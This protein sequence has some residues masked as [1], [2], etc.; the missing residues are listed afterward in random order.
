MELLRAYRYEI[1]AVVIGLLV[2]SLTAS[3]VRQLL[4]E[5]LVTY[6]FE[7]LFGV[8]VLVTAGVGYRLWTH[9]SRIDFSTGVVVQVL[10]LVLAVPIAA[11]SGGLLYDAHD[12]WAGSQAHWHAGFTVVV[13]GEQ[14]NL[15]D[16][17]QFCDTFL[18]KKGERVGTHYLHEHDDEAIHVHGPIESQ[19]DA[20]L[21]A[22]FNTFG[23]ELASDTLQFPTNAGWVNRTTDENGTVKVLVKRAGNE[24][25][26]HVEKPG[27]YVMSKRQHEP[28]D[29][30]VIIYD[31]RTVQQALED[32][33]S[34]GYYRGVSADSTDT[35]R[36]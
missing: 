27:E 34:D 26:Q 18:C 7:V 30:I 15:I 2:G 16:P 8:S 14:Q 19:D 10:V 12:A 3:S 21:G 11:A 31:N 23:G 9:R 28:L 25:W 5:I 33:R 22:F 6:M 17:E 24:T 4:V 36:D 20:T 35:Y 1:V 32:A 29:S 13:D